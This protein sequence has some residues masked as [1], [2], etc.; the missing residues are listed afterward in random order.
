MVG[1]GPVCAVVVEG[2]RKSKK[3]KKKKKMMMMMIMIMIRVN[4]IKLP[5][6][7]HT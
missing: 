5:H 7:G 3:K 4:Y 1:Y 2:V 6:F